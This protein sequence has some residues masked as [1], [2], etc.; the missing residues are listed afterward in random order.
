MSGEPL[1]TESSTSHGPSKDL[2]WF[3]SAIATCWA[4][5]AVLSLQF[6]IL[7]LLGFCSLVLMPLIMLLMLVGVILRLR[8]I[9][10]HLPNRKQ[11]IAAFLLAIPI[12]LCPWKPNA[13]PASGVDKICIGLPAF[14]L[15]LRQNN[16]WEIV[17]GSLW[18]DLFFWV[19][20]SLFLAPFLSRKHTCDKTE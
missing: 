14:W 7:V 18:M 4:V 12:F 17:S 9:S 8:R 6:P 3:C 15:G 16:H 13:D 19:N 1:P 11:L 5:I 2:L 20:G 10:R